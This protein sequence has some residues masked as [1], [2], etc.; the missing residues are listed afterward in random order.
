MTST[1]PT[2]CL[3]GAMEIHRRLLTES[4]SYR[5]ARAQLETATMGFTALEVDET[6]VARVPV[7]VHVVHSTDQQNISDAQVHSQIAVLNEDFRATNADTGTVPGVFADLVHD[8]RVEFVLADVDP[9]GRQT[10][11]ITR[12]RTRVR[13]FGTD[14]GVKDPARGGVAAWPAD[15]YLN[16]WVAQLS[17]G[18]LGYA[19]FPGGP[20]ETDGVVITYTAFGTT[21]TATAPFH[22]G[23]TATHEIGHYFNLFHIWGDDGTG[24]GGTDEVDDTP[25][26]AG[27]N[28]GKPAWPHV[29]CRN[30][31]HGDLFMD[32]MDY[33]DDDMMVMFTPG[34][35]ARMWAC[36]QLERKAMWTAAA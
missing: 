26:Q 31:P 13:T 2:G 1:E 29:T 28:T 27:P 22:L 15:R 35:V 9:D 18:L 36:L 8:A 5:I 6:V 10:T 12:T 25:N 19:Q 4:E 23:R 14:D 33:V 34:Q 30:G 24:C 11:G 3:C 20:A 17:G 21:G 32:Y 7:V 16:I